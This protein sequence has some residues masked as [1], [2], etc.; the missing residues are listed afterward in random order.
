MRSE[1]YNTGAP[2]SETESLF[3]CG[4]DGLEKV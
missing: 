2:R 1:V 3:P 4:A